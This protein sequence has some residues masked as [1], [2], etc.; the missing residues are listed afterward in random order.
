MGSVHFH[1]IY[2]DTSVRAYKSAG[3]ATDACIWIGHVSIVITAVVDLVSLKRQ[4]VC[5][6]CHHTEVTP[7]ATLD[8]DCDGTFYFCHT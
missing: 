6:T 7:L 1:A 3:T 2:F 5:R 8:V 4:S